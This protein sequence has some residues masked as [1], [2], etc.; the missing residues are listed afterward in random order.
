M[1]AH[2]DLAANLSKLAEKHRQYANA[3]HAFEKNGDPKLYAKLLFEEQRAR[4][5]LLDMTSVIVACY[6]TLLEREEHGIEVKP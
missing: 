6:A 5:A 1:I 2:P 4:Q 3:Q